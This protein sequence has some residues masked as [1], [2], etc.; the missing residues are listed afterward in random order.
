[1]N[2][3]IKQILIIVTTFLVILWFQTEDD[4]KNKRIRKSFLETYKLPLLVSSIVGLL[5]NFND[6]FGLDEKEKYLMPRKHVDQLVYVTPEEI[7]MSTSRPSP[8]EVEQMPLARMK[9]LSNFNKIHEMA[10]PSGM[11]L[12]KVRVSNNMNQEIF[13]ELPDF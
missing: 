6:I 3:L 9:E 2:L 10:K 1:M 13:T 8:M 12:P 7:L 4:K 5:I 11:S